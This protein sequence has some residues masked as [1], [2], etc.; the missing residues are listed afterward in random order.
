MV[1]KYEHAAMYEPIQELGGISH[2]E[3][4]VINWARKAQVRLNTATG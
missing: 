2:I 1:G 3:A 4:G